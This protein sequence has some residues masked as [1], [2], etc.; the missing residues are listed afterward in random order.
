MNSLPTIESA[1]SVVGLQLRDYQREALAE[2]SCQRGIHRQLIR[3]SDV[4]VPEILRSAR[5]GKPVAGNGKK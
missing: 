5:T 1:Q 4:D 3:F 2:E